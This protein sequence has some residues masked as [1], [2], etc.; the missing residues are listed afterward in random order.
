MNIRARVGKLEM[1]IGRC[2][3][4]REMSQA[5]LEA[6]IKKARGLGDDVE[7]TDA[8]LHSLSGQVHAEVAGDQL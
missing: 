7:I 3:S 6:V 2:L 1:T 8:L 5:Q 4:A